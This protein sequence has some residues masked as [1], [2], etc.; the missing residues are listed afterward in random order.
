MDPAS[1]HVKPYHVHSSV[2]LN[3]S[4]G[5]DHDD[6]AVVVAKNRQAK[7]NRCL[8]CHWTLSAEGESVVVVAAVELM[9]QSHA[10]D[11]AESGTWRLARV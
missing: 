4:H 6:D 10:C 11:C 7:A 3:G 9:S 1:S 8:S 2:L 5:L